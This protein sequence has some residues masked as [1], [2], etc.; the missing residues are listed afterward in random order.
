MSKDPKDFAD[1]FQSLQASGKL[2][3]VEAR[4]DKQR[5]RASSREAYKAQASRSKLQ[6]QFD[7]FSDPKGLTNAL[8]AFATALL[9]MT[10][11][12][13][14]RKCSKLNV[15]TGPSAEQRKHMAIA[16]A[17]WY[18]PDLADPDC[19]I[20]AE[21]VTATMRWLTSNWEVAVAAVDVS[22]SP[23]PAVTPRSLIKDHKPS[24]CAAL[25]RAARRLK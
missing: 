1:A 13:R 20:I 3:K 19:T 24:I 12:G 9:A 6:A 14:G 17:K 11:H 2:D 7:T 18:F 5:K 23:T 10:F 8:E 21:D 15:S 25:G 16:Y 22:S 4:L